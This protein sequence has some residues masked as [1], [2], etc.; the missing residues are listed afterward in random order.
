MASLD[1]APQSVTIQ[2]S[3]PA[4]VDNDPCSYKEA[5][6]YSTGI[7]ASNVLSKM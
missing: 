2:A 4:C 5:N 7:F 6:S 3:L 1:A